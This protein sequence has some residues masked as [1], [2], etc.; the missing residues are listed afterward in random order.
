MQR[1]PLSLIYIK[2]LIFTKSDLKVGVGGPG[3]DEVVIV[4]RPGS[5]LLVTSRNGFG[6]GRKVGGSGGA[7][8]FIEVS[9]DGRGRFHSLALKVDV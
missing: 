9:V 3:C 5:G 8:E 2:H 7:S 1:M 4:G 6:G